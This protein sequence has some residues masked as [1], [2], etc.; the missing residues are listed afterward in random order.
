[1]RL[2]N[3]TV[4]YRT[5]SLI[6][7]FLSM[8]LILKGILVLEIDIINILTGFFWP[9]VGMIIAILFLKKDGYTTSASEIMFF[10]FILY[11]G[12]YLIFPSISILF[13]TQF[14][15]NSLLITLNFIIIG[16]GW[17]GIAYYIIY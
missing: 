16:L 17:L 4:F 8:L 10:L 1:M 11:C 12:I 14:A 13:G 3:A 9:I 6:C 7:F 15:E 5:L 2:T